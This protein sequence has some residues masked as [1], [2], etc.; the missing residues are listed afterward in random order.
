VFV[1]LLAGRDPETLLPPSPGQ[2]DQADGRPEPDRNPAGAGAPGNRQGGSGGPGPGGLAALTGT[3][4]LVMPAAAWLG[5]TDAPG[6][7]AG[8]GPLDAWT[9]RDLAARLAAGP[10]TRWHVTLTGPDGRA[11]AHATPRAGPGPPA[12]PGGCRNWLAGLR[13]DRLEHRTCSHLR[14]TPRYHPPDR[15]QNL[16]RARQRTCSFPGCRRPATRCDLDHTLPYNQ[17]GPTCECNLSPLCRRHHRTKQ[18]AGWNL[19]QPQP[20]I[21][22]WATPHSRTYTVTPD[23]YLV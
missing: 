10:A 2:H 8:L 14:Q 18:A 3:V 19:T 5:L 20:G 1:A 6:E 11:T 13:F 21:L 17:G 15:L 23:P 22:I 16:I 4:H 9:C 12:Q 7:A